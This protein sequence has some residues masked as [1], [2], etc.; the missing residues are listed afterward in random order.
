MAEESSPPPSK[1][2]E[3]GKA[4]SRRPFSVLLVVL[5]FVVIALALGLGLGLGL[6]LKKHAKPASQISPN[7]TTGSEE[8]SFASFE[9]QPWRQS[10]LGYNLSLDDWDFNAAPTTRVYNLTIAEI[11]AAP[12]G[13]SKHAPCELA[14][15][16][17][18]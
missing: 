4:P 8:P 13:K 6:G 12:D 11:A 1:T 14:A 16:S 15:F 10:T 3:S 17:R 7:P 5:L 9:V 2:E 18:L